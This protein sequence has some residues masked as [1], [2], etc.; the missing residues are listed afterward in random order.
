[1]HVTE[2]E[3]KEE[4]ILHAACDC[5]QNWGRGCEIII[6]NMEKIRSIPVEEDKI[7]EIVHEYGPVKIYSSEE[8][9]AVMERLTLRDMA[10]LSVGGGMTGS[11]FFEAPGAAGVTCTTLEQKGI[12]NVVMGRWTG[13]ASS[14][15]GFICVIHR[16]GKRDRAEYFM[17]EISSGAG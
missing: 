5:R 12:P 17:Y 10:E 16:K 7:T 9:D 11:R 4:D 15:Q 3:Q 2:L 13:R 1:M 14:E 8:T 6:E